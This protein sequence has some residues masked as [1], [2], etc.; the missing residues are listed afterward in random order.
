MS[1]V[2]HFMTVRKWHAHA[3]L[4]WVSLCKFQQITEL[5][6]CTHLIPPHLPQQ[7]R[8]NLIC[9][10]TAWNELPRAATRRSE[11]LWTSPDHTDTEY[12]SEQFHPAYLVFAQQY[13]GGEHRCA[14]IIRP[15]VRCDRYQCPDFAVLREDYEYVI[16]E[17]CTDDLCWNSIDF[18]LRLSRSDDGLSGRHFV[19]LGEEKETANDTWRLFV[20]LKSIFI[21]DYSVKYSLD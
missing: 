15:G 7:F 10:F 4:K 12:L 18:F 3:E 8:P 20:V 6:A 9:P 21:I 5:H 11:V 13:F 14:D 16:A 19:N 2:L 17:F 1:H